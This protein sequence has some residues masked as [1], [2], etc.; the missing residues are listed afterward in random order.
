[1]STK[2]KNLSRFWIGFLSCSCLYSL[3]QDALGKEEYLRLIEEHWVS[4][5]VSVPLAVLGLIVATWMYQRGD[6]NG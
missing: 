2:T 5:V 4:G 3:A 6:E 1:M